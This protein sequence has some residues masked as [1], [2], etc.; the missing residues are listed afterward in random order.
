M[1]GRERD[2]QTEKERDSNTHTEINL[3]EIF[4]VTDENFTG[5]DLGQRALCRA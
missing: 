2:F 1:P 4:L 5:K 3:M